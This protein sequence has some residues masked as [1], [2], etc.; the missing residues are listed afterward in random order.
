MID[1]FKG[2]KADETPATSAAGGGSGAVADA[3]PSA[4]ASSGP[5]VSTDKHKNYAVFAG[6]ATIAAAAGWY[7]RATKPKPEEVQD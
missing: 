2:P 4:E 5:K 1:C 6:I 3:K 7:W